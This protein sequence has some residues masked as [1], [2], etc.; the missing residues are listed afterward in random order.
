MMTWAYAQRPPASASTTTAIQKSWRVI[1][2]SIPEWLDVHAADWAGAYAQ[3]FRPMSSL[4]DAVRLRSGRVQTRPSGDVPHRA[5]VDCDRAW[6]WHHLCAVVFY[7][8]TV[9]EGTEPFELIE[10]NQ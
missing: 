8:N 6:W 10:S 1:A 9:E 4:R 3:S 7:P 2:A 5:T